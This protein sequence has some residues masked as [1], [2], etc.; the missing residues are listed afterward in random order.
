M[1]LVD[2]V[3]WWVT[4]ACIFRK[5]DHCPGGPSKTAGVQ[6]AALNRWLLARLST[7]ADGDPAAEEVVRFPRTV[8][9]CNKGAPRLNAEAQL[10]E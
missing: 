6:F 2:V 10:K 1:S 5:K 4:G 9:R 8:G 3:M 7:S